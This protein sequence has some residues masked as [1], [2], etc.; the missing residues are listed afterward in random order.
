VN[1]HTQTHIHTYTHVSTYILHTDTH[2]REREST[3]HRHTFDAGYTHMC[4]QKEEARLKSNNIIKQTHILTDLGALAGSRG[5][6][7][8]CAQLIISVC[9]FPER[10]T[11]TRPLTCTHTRVRGATEPTVTLPGVSRCRWF[12][13]KSRFQGENTR[14]Q[15]H[16]H[17]ET[18]KRNNPSQVK[19]DNDREG[20]GQRLR[21][22]QSAR[23]AS[24][25]GIVVGAGEEVTHDMPAET[26]AD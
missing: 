24:S 19:T 25:P 22:T 18:R 20:E 5:A 16:D 4:A 6:K 23:F 7:E 21:R 11:Y 2:A 3:L 15:G 12:H 17:M 14:V 13:A 8:D 10:F 26:Q 9:H 1:V